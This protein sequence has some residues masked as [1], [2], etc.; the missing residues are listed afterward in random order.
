MF[1]FINKYI[2]IFNVYKTYN[3]NYYNAVNINNLLLY[4]IKNDYINN[5]IM[6]KILKDNYNNILKLIKQRYNDEIIIQN[7][8]KKDEEN[9]KKQ[10]VIEKEANKKIEEQ[11]K[12]NMNNIKE[13]EKYKEEIQN[14][15]KKVSIYIYHYLIIG[16]KSIII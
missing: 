5:N 11:E 6:K 9:S 14:L 12:K 8:E 2:D 7:K 1:N 16:S 10:K 15:K 4:Y 13:L 3:N